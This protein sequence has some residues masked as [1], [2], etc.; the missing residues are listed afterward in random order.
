MKAKT[1]LAR[2]NDGTASVAELEDLDEHDREVTF[3]TFTRHVDLRTI[4]QLLGY[5]F[6][7]GP[8]LNLRRDWHVR[9]Y[10]SSF[11]GQPCWHLDW[12]AIDHIF[13]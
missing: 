3:S 7:R 5:Q 13:V 1:L 8:G 2:C 9:Y 11:R 6:G 10:R 12:S 4:S